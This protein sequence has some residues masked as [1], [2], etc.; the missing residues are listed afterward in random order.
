MGYFFTLKSLLVFMN[1]SSDCGGWGV[2]EVEEGIEVING[3]GKKCIQNKIKRK[4]LTTHLVMNQCQQQNNES[5][6][7]STEIFD[8]H[9]VSSK[10]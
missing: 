5:G 9:K 1:Y 6:F 7:H 4:I 3:D 8:N 2:V 10:L